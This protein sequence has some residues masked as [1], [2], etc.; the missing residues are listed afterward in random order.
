MKT[1]LTV[2][3][4]VYL[5][6][7]VPMAHVRMGTEVVV[8]RID[9]SLGGAFHTSWVAHALGLSVVLAFPSGPGIS[10]LAAS[11]TIKSLG[12]SSRTWQA[13]EDTAISLVFT[14]DNDRAFV[15]AA[16]FA[17]LEHCPD[18][19][20][21]AWIHVP[22]LQEARILQR[23]LEA[24]K[25]SGSRISVAA[26][27]APGELDLLSGSRPPWDLL[28]L[29]E[30]EAERAT[31]TGTGDD[32]LDRLVSV[33]PNVIVTRAARGAIGIVDGE[34]FS[35]PARKIEVSNATGAGDAFAA[36]YL[37]AYANGAGPRKSAEIANEVAGRHVGARRRLDPALFADIK[38]S[39]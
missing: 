33:V 2:A 22:G 4:L 12:L 17:A 19:G 8:D 14:A 3:G 7:A 34:H 21:S 23:H 13:R 27:W 5:D 32:A 11:M 36:G 30:L 10:D 16:D 37:A 31:G 20:G 35:A 25:A 28:F 26:S 24:A 9:V 15:S 39:G 18:L 1:T 29:N 38:L 6:V